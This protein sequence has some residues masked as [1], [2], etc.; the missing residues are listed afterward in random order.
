MRDI[1]VR[2]ID[3]EGKPEEEKRVTFFKRWKRQ[4]GS[5]ATYKVLIS[6]LLQTKRREDAECV[7]ELLKKFTPRKTKRTEDKGTILTL[8]AWFALVCNNRHSTSPPPI[9]PW[10]TYMTSITCSVGVEARK[11]IKSEGVWGGK[12]L[13]WNEV[14]QKQCSFRQSRVL[15]LYSPSSPYMWARNANQSSPCLSR[16]VAR[17][18]WV[19]VIWISLIAYTVH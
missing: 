9:R 15:S 1:V 19:C 17:T 18:T 2:D 14:L 4:K 6:A 16:G 11:A 13:Q 5:Q 8:Q 12:V 3:R 10:C 7:C